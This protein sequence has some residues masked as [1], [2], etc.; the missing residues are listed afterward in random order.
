MGTIQHGKIHISGGMQAIVIFT[1]A[2]MGSERLLYFGSTFVTLLRTTAYSDI[3]ALYVCGNGHEFKSY[4][5]DTSN[6]SLYGIQVD[7]G[8]SATHLCR[9]NF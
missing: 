6:P 2:S 7:G 8:E 1:H 9:P 4:Y 3:M 5:H